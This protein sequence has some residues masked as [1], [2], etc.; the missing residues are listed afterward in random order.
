MDA[1]VG[2][3]TFSLAQVLARLSAVGRSLKRQMEQ[4]V[5]L[6]SPIKQDV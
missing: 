6:Q 2:G 5:L 3:T 4:V 1:I